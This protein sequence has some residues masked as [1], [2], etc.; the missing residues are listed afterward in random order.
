M[1]ASLPGADQ[2]I[3]PQSHFACRPSDNT[4]FDCHARSAISIKRGHKAGMRGPH[5]SN[6]PPQPIVPDFWHFTEI[7]FGRTAFCRFTAS[8][9]H[10]SAQVAL[11]L[12]N[13]GCAR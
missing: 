12:S 2:P 8:Q 10:A 9:D 4:Q 1:N 13:S 6:P 7:F 3:V 5:A 11:Q